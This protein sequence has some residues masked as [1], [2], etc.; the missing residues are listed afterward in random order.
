M[1]GNF[2]QLDGHFEKCG[3]QPDFN[4]L[5]VSNQIT[6]VLYQPDELVA[7]GAGRR[8]IGKTFQNVSFSKTTLRG[9]TFRDCTFQDCLFIGSRIEHCEF[10]GCR[11]ANCNTHKI[12]IE[13]TYVDPEVFAKMLHPKQHANIGV[14]LFQQLL[15]NAT[16]TQQPT[17]RNSA[18]YHFR[19]W[20]RYQWDYDV[21]TGRSALLPYL[22]KWLPEWLY[23]VFAGYGLRSRFFM[24]WS[25][26]FFALV[27][28]INH[29]LWSVLEITSSGK[30]VSE[31]KLIQS[32]YFSLVTL[33]T[34]GYGDLVPSS[35]AGMGIIT[36]EAILGIIWV[37]ILASIVIR[38]VVR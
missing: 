23:F 11:F 15:K 25:V 26:V 28:I 20:R 18:E 33:T 32:T 36:V 4:T 3:S 21:K 34:L 37:S 6:D 10:H 31:A 9:W 24:I 22:C 13:S 29:T 17:F 19:N 27:I 12:E 5:L 8:I 16:D 38:R 30:A 14:H 1:F 35:D 7:D 2:F